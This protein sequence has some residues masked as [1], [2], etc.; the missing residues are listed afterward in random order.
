[1]RSSTWN[2]TYQHWIP[3][4]LLKGFGIRGQSSKVFELDRET[5]NIEVRRVADAASKQRLLTERDDELMKSIEQRTKDLIGR[6]RKGKLNLN[7]E[8]RRALDK[9]VFALMHND[10]YSGFDDE[11]TR[12]K[13]VDSLSNMVVEAFAQQGGAINIQDMRDY[14]NE[15]WSHDYLSTMIEMEEL[16]VL[17]ALR[18]MGLSA[19]KP[20]DSESFLLGDSPVLVA[21]GT[22]SGVTD[23]R[24]PGSQIILPIQS[25]CMLVYSWE[26]PFNLIQSGNIPGSRAGSFLES[27]LLP[28]VE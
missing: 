23:L 19:H 1:M 16:M 13:I 14:T 8:D 15:L 22:V 7:E 9:L 2:D 10:P 4:F 26:T 18:F 21:R 12:R 17:D 28:G 11:T 6:I 20:V 3:Q 24:N 27:G 5:G 25:R